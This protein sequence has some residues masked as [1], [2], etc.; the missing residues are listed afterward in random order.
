ML[1][2][3]LRRLEVPL[4]IVTAP[5]LGDSAQ[6]S[7]M[8]NILA[9][10]AEFERE[11][12][13]SRI[14]D[15]RALL[16]QRHLRFA[17]GVPFG[18]DADRRTKQLMP[19]EEESAVVKWMFAEAA[20]GRKPADIAVAANGLGYRTKVSIALRTGNKR[21]GNLWTARQVVATLRNPVH[22]G[23]LRRTSLSSGPEC[24]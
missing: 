13:A 7:F 6:D 14:A 23:M 21:G 8:L 9:S 18:Y 22:I 11:M 19:N 1:L 16:K 4:F 12:I 20:A 15:T 24:A 10:F 2:D 5:D 17:G 3:E